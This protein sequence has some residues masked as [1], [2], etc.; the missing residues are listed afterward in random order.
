MKGNRF[1]DLTPWA[2]GAAACLL[3]LGT[4]S[5]HTS[6]DSIEYAL[7]IESAKPALLLDPYHPLLHPA[8]LLFFRLWQ[9]AGWAGR[10]LLPLQVLNA[11]AG[12]V[13]AGLVT[14]IARVLSK[15][16]G[17]AAAAGLGF[18]VSGGTWMLSVEAEFVTPPLAL[19]LGVVWG[20]LSVA[21]VTAAR[22]RYPILMGAATAV[23]VAGYASNLLLAPVVLV[24]L[25]ADDRL[26]PALRRRHSRIYVAILML[27]LVPAC[28]AFV[29]AWSG[30]A[31]QQAPAYFFG[32]SYSRFA[33]LDIPHGVYAFL[34]SLAL[35]PNLSLG[36]TTRQFL[37]HASTPGR[38]LFAGYYGLVLLAILVPIGLGWRHRDDLWPSERRPL[39]VLGTWSALFAAF[40]FYWVPGDPSFWL[41]VLAAWWLAVALVLGATQAKGISAASVVA[42]VAVLALG[43]AL[44]EV[45]PRHDIRRN[46][47]YQ[48]TQQVLANTT[49]ADVLLVRGDDIAGLYLTYWGNRPVTYLPSDVRIPEEFLPGTGATETAS[50]TVASRLILID[51]DDRRAGWWDA[52]LK[53]SVQAAPEKWVRSVPGWHAG[54]GLVMEMSAAPRSR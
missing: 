17:L 54:D 37:A 12:G 32:R 24:G 21:G 52:L 11:L 16:R 50:G 5:N 9:L 42:A 49:P 10:A 22:G 48:V 15:S 38:L 46:V 2:V 3:Y 51:S 36:G 30:S 34:R 41:P 47:G 13:C 27:L 33:P 39:L 29:A 35:Y 6:G 18:A 26:A 31:W 20:V 1:S 53:A 7:A 43:N 23:A 25:L 28:L 4:L 14:A 8:G 40:G 45:V 44:F 19:A